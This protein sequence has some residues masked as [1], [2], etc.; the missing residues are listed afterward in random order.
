MSPQITDDDVGKSVV[1][2]DGDEVGMVAD[3]QH[4][5]AHVEPDPG[6]TDSIKATLGWGDSGEDTYPLQEEAIGRVTDDEIRLE[7]DLSG[8][9]TTGGTGDMDTGAGT[10]GTGTGTRDDRGIDRDENDISGSDDE[11]VIRD[12]D[13]DL[14]GDDNTR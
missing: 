14:L 10:T 8:A 13:D 9:N 4:G 11:G 5:T 3:V 12:D 7:R 2:A 1:N 6:I